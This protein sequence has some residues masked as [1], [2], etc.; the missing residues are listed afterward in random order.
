[1][2]NEVKNLGGRPRGSGTGQQITARL[3][4]EIY[5]ALDITKKGWQAVG[6][7]DRGSIAAGRGRNYQQNSVGYCRK[8]SN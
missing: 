7:A 5:S 6:Y 1:M 4:K 2:A 8:R 3:R